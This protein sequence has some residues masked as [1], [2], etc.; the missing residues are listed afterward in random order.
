MSD[1]CGTCGY[2]THIHLLATGGIY[3]PCPECDRVRPWDDI[4]DAFPTPWE[5]LK[6]WVRNKLRWF[7]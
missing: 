6:G 7:L 4:Q 1:I 5:T 3:A 2:E